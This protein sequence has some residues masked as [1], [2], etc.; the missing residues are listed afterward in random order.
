MFKIFVVLFWCCLATSF[1]LAANTHEDEVCGVFD[2]SKKYF[3]ND[4]NERWSF[5]WTAALMRLN[6]GNFEYLCG[7]TLLSE[8][9]VVT[10]KLELLKT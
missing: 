9:H 1:T 7:G 5:P 8:S 2:R 4:N 6:G 3:T 10:G